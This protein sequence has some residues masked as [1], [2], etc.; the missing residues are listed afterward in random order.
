MDEDRLAIS[1]TSADGSVTRWG[2]DEPDASRIPDDLEF[3]SAIPGGYKDMRCSL[4]RTMDG[5][6]HLFAR[7]RA[8]GP[9]N[10]TAW[11]GR[12]VQFPR[13]EFVVAPGAV[14]HAAQLLDDPSFREVYI[15]RDLSHWTP[16]PYARKLSL[17]ATYGWTDHNVGSSSA[18]TPSINAELDGAWG[19]NGLPICEAWYDMGPGLFVG[20]MA[21]SWERTN[22]GSTS[23][24]WAIISVINESAGGG[25]SS[26]DL[27]NEPNTT[28]TSNLSYAA[29]QGRY[30]ILQFF[31][32]GANVANGQDN[33]KF[34]VSW[35]NV[36]IMSQHGLTIQGTVPN[37][38]FYGHDVINDIVTRTAPLLTSYVGTGSVETNTGFV[39][40]QATFLEPTTGDQAVRLINGYFLWEWGVY[41]DLTF[42]WR[43]PDPNRLVWSARRSRGA[44][45]SFEGLT[46]DE[47]F[48]GVLVRYTDVLG[49]RRMAG[50]PSTYWQGG[51]ARCDV[52]DA[53]LVDT[54]TTN[55]VN[56]AGI[57][58]R[59][60]ILDVGPVTTDIGAV[61]IGVVWLAE[62]A[63]PQ[64]RG[65]ITINGD[66]EHPTEGLVPP[67]RVRA[68][69]GVVVPDL[70]G[71]EPRRIIET[72]YRRRDNSNVL[73]VGNPDFKLDAILERIG[74][75]LAGVL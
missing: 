17:V 68:G 19:V 64:R 58:R 70:A 1:V 44:E 50:P 31:W 54:S 65:T 15:D 74:V 4:F 13:D 66:V 75:Q 30:G 62:H 60:G 63:L 46:A 41:D 59:W 29:T 39:I 18:G 21:A 10:R 11:D 32:N 53:N 8:Y 26:G 28:G 72:R 49:R 43:A 52:T 20:R 14:G 25:N 34:V 9:G 2:G 12:L 7:T 73:T 67:W 27:Q 3:G 37:E 35:S 71:D 36:R 55:A 16:M 22:A 5:P 38:G 45:V 61:Q 24:Q 40:P 51:V 48:N 69:D 47:Q 56:F 23:W 42:F 6:E 33:V 57:P